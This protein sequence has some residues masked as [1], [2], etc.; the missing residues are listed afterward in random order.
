MDLKFLRFLMGKP[1]FHNTPEPSMEC[2]ECNRTL[3]IS[4]VLLD[5]KTYSQ[6]RELLQAKL[7]KTIEKI[8]DIFNEKNVNDNYAA[9]KKFCLSIQAPI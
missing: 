6:K 9:V 8:E 7:Q 4:H 5:C 2:T 1:Y 3:T